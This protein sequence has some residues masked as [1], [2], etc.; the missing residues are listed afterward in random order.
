LHVWRS[1]PQSQFDR[2]NDISPADG[3]FVVKLEPGCIYSLTTTTG[4]ACQSLVISEQTFHRWQ[5]QY[6]RQNTHDA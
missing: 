5:A 2:Q 1:N 4:Q 6:E 3:A